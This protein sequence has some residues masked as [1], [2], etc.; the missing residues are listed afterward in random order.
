[1]KLAEYCFTLNV[2]TLIQRLKIEKPGHLDPISP[3]PWAL[4]IKAETV[5]P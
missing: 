4:D 1:M 2:W 3:E 5:N